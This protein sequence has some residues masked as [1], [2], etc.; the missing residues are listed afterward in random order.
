VKAIEYIVAYFHAYLLKIF[1][2]IDCLFWLIL[3]G[4][5][6]VMGVVVDLIPL[7]WILTKSFALNLTSWVQPAT[8]SVQGRML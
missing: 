1:C 6:A 2:N 4:L 3:Q 7:L 8:Y 5:L